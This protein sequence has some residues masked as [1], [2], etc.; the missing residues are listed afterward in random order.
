MSVA[1]KPILNAHIPHPNV[2]LPFGHM[3]EWRMPQ[4]VSQSSGLCHEGIDTGFGGSQADSHRPGD[5]CDL[6]AVAEPIVNGG[7]FSW[8]HD[9]RDAGKAGESSRVKNSIAITLTG[10]SGIGLLGRGRGDCV[11]SMTSIVSVRQP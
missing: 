3:T 6:Q 2:E 5:L 8:W 1:F 7:A 10:G 11:R 9:L 4:I